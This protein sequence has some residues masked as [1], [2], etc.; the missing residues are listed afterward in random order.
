M[1][2]L[3]VEVRLLICRLRKSVLCYD[4]VRA[5]SPHSSGLHGVTTE[6]HMTDF[7]RPSSSEHQL[8]YIGLSALDSSY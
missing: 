5:S 7:H 2:N 8:L 6:P 4:Q 1:T 3:P